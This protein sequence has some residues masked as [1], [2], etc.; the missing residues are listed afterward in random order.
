MSKHNQSASLG[1]LSDFASSPATPDE[2]PDRLDRLDRIENRLENIEKL[3][4]TVLYAVT[5]LNETVDKVSKTP[6]Q[7][8]SPGLPREGQKNHKTS[9]PVISEPK[10]KQAPPPKKQKPKKKAKASPSSHF[11]PEQQAEINAIKPRVQGL[12]ADRESLTKAEAVKLL[13]EVDPKLIG[14]V[15]SVLVA[16]AFLSMTKPEATDE[17]PDPKVVFTR[18]QQTEA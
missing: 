5:D 8:S 9:P 1:S 13:P 16:E 3:L 10:R 18:K 2:K 4:N 17:T 11:T 15:L 14:R 6:K 12:F 7:T